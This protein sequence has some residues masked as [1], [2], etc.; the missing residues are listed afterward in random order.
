MD[1][2]LLL[3]EFFKTIEGSLARGLDGT[4]VISINRSCVSLS[5]RQKG[6]A[7]RKFASTKRKIYHDAVPPTIVTTAPTT[8]LPPGFD[9]PTH[10]IAP[11]PRDSIDTFRDG[12]VEKL[13]P[14]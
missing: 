14:E 11:K 10:T 8:S 9:T 6:S 5:L 7:M 12:T 2:N 3:L 13:I 1:Q 4:F